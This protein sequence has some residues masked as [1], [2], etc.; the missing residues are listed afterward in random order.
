[1]TIEL[2]PQQQHD[3]DSAEDQPLRVV[4]PRTRTAYVLI[5]A[6]EFNGVRE[7]LEDEKLQRAVRRVALRTAVGRANEEP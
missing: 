6:E 3:L 4:D 5:P 2:T 7:A 1:M